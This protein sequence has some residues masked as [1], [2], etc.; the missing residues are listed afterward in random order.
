VDYSLVLT[1]NGNSGAADGKA[2]F[3][4][5][6]SIGTFAPAKIPASMSCKVSREYN[7]S[8]KIA[9]FPSE[10][11]RTGQGTPLSASAPGFKTAGP[12]ML[13]IPFLR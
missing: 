10:S 8:D 7:G 3:A 2:R 6:Y 5:D 9:H 1:W 13:F 11:L 12:A 4:S